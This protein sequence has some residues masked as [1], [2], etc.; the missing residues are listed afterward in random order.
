MPPLFYGFGLKLTQTRRGCFLTE[1]F[2]PKQGLKTR[3]AWVDG[4]SNRAKI[5]NYETIAGV[6][7]LVSVIFLGINSAA[8]LLWTNIRPNNQ[9]QDQPAFKIIRKR[10][11][12]IRGTLPKATERHIR[13]VP[14]EH[15]KTKQNK[16][17]T[18]DMVKIA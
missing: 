15:F 6:L 16:V 5:S 1:R 18:C 4:V 10:P 7:Y 17:F 9:G 14:T 3:S 12:D 8:S 11:Y 2:G 13:D